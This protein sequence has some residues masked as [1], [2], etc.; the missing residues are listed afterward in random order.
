VLNRPFALDPA[1]VQV[2][3]RI[4]A[5][6]DMHL[7]ILP[8][9]YY[10]DTPAPDIG[11]ARLA[12]IIG[13][14]REGSPNCLLFDNGDFLTGTPMSDPA[15]MGDRAAE[16][17]P[18]I[19]AMNELHYDAACVGNHEFNAG[20][21]YLAR[22]TRN[23]NFPLL[24]AN[25]VR[26]SAL[27]VDSQEFLFQPEIIVE[28]PVQTSDGGTATVKVG[29]FGLTPPQILSWDKH[30][31]PESVGA[32][33]MVEAAFDAVRRLR[34][35]GS[36]IIVALCHTGLGDEMHVWGME[37]ALVPLAAVDGIDVLIAGHTHQVFPEASLGRHG[38]VDGINGL[39]HG[40][41]VVMA[42]SHGSHLGVIDL[43]LEKSARGWTQ[44]A[45]PLVQ[46]MASSAT[47]LTNP[48]DP[49]IL[50]SVSQ[51]H[52]RT[53]T[54]IRRP[55]GETSGPLQSY[56]AQVAPDPTLWLMSQAQRAHCLPLL[57][58][59][60]LRGIPVLVSVAPFR[61]GG[62][63]G[64]K[65]YIDIPAGALTLRNAAE[66]YPHPDTCMALKLSGRDV[67][68]WLD[69]SATA[70]MPVGP[71]SDSEPAL[72][73]PKRPSYFFDVFDGL[74][75]DI[76]LT[77]PSPRTTNIQTVAGPLAPEAPVIVITNSY[78]AGGGGGFAM[79]QTGEILVE[80]RVV[81]RDMVVD[82]I[83]KAGVVAPK[84]QR[85]WRFAACHRGQ[86]ARFPTGPGARHYLDTGE[87]NGISGGSEA[88]NGFI[89]CRIAL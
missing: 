33:D 63:A 37:N 48:G 39:I 17:H 53:L 24:S 46:A 3:L 66:L 23:A 61:S 31:L 21:D 89:S 16:E 14:I 78:R 75:Y 49:A 86:T 56:F 58:Y 79:A 71:R 87:A 7:H 74:T 44:I 41:P 36:D 57:D 12:Q 85:I 9:D 72:L 60:A 83:R 55:I 22:A 35:A 40:K 64:P 84:A 52:E 19:R 8:Y 1:K 4:L 43:T 32:R 47:S 73:N 2:H 77:G 27:E 76:D 82:Y 80:S 50:A 67:Q 59:Q 30:K 42:G 20:L 13:G 29:V 28:K 81:A 6:T 25:V 54:Y 26:R 69:Q 5:T 18:A 65:N 68:A 38:P 10:S 15:V 34:A 45:P 11:L 70:F 62:Q 88:E 51:E